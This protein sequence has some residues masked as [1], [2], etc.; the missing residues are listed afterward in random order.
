MNFIPSYQ[1]SPARSTSRGSDP[2]KF[3]TKHK[4]SSFEEDVYYQSNHKKT[5]LNWQG[6]RIRSLDSLHLF[7]D[8]EEL[9]LS[10]NLINE[11]TPQI[12]SWYL[13]LK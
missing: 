5:S 8:L 3:N 7:P 1:E 13:I 2:S 4:E 9:N 6:N 12:N 11:I 10:N